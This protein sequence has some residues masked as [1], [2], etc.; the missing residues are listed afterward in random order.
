MMTL[1]LKYLPNV[2]MV[3]KPLLLLCYGVSHGSV[4]FLVHYL[5]GRCFY[6]MSGGC[7]VISV[8]H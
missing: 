7:A 3:E 4:R 2:I 8:A 5:L 6:I 1:Q